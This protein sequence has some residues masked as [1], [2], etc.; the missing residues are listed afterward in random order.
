MEPAVPRL[1][2]AME[3]DRLLL[4]T[5]APYLLPYVITAPN[6]TWK[7]HGQ[8]Y[9]VYD[10]LGVKDVP[11]E[12]YVKARYITITLDRPV[13]RGFVWFW[14]YANGLFDPDVED[15]YWLSLSLEERLDACDYIS[16][17]ETSS[18]YGWIA[19]H[20]FDGIK[21]DPSLASERLRRLI[22]FDGFYSE[23]LPRWGEC[24]IPSLIRAYCVIFSVPI[25]TLPNYRRLKPVDLQYEENPT[26]VVVDESLY[27]CRNLRRIL[28]MTLDIEEKLNALGFDVSE[29]T[30]YDVAE[31][32][33]LYQPEGLG[34]TMLYIIDDIPILYD[35]ERFY[36]E[37][38][39]ATFYIGIISRPIIEISRHV[40]PN[41]PQSDPRSII[42]I[43]HFISDVRFPIQMGGVK[44][45]GDL[46]VMKMRSPLIRAMVDDGD[47]LVFPQPAEGWLPVWA[48]LNG[49]SASVIELFSSDDR[50]YREGTIPLS[51]EEEGK[52]SLSTLSADE[53]D[54][55][56]M[57][58]SEEG[59]LSLDELPPIT[60]DEWLSLSS[61]KH[62]N[63]FQISLSSNWVGEYIFRIFEQASEYIGKDRH[64]LHSELSG[65]LKSIP[66]S[67]KADYRLLSPID[68]GDRFVPISLADYFL[69]RL[70]VPGDTIFSLEGENL[71]PYLGEEIG[72]DIY[73]AL[74]NAN[75]YTNY[76][77][78]LVYDP[79]PEGHLVNGILGLEDVSTRYEGGKWIATR[80]G[81]ILPIVITL[82]RKVE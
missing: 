14:Y 53:A 21:P 20:L 42:T 18:L 28:L 10:R 61:W 82:F 39:S 27:Y 68:N 50:R 76:L 72:Q 13:G 78:P 80:H 29:D 56:P 17:Y 22:H 57:I 43:N 47:D 60:P 8:V 2:T 41:A 35:G 66:Y 12:D 36:D 55:L 32:R 26:M 67:D 59:K 46:L 24:L 9:V 40:Y 38:T 19:N 51:L 74:W 34:N 49:L 73:V 23:L 75:I 11:I 6:G 16:R 3:E 37:G 31:I 70:W 63:Y 44:V 79:V 77:F 4:T 52:V 69:A 62:I 64:S 25:N 58:I 5:G 81:A 71:I 7:L 1:S 65:I 30:E 15:K 54:E 45:H 33:C 48:Y